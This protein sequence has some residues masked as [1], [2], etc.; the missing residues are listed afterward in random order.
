MDAIGFVM[1]H[2]GHFAPIDIVNLLFAMLVATLL[3]YLL[4]RLGARQTPIEARELALWAGLSAM[5]AGL[6]RAQLPLAVVL[7]ALVLLSKGREGGRAGQVLVFA[8]LIMGLGCG[9]GASLVMLV[10]ALPF[11]L[12]IRWAFGAERA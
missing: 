11:I 9:S 8:A 6:V 12:V 4:G 3:G 5:G 1:D 7:L 10:V 2:L